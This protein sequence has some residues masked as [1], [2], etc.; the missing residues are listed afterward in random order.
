MHLFILRDGLVPGVKERKMTEIARFKR[1]QFV[2]TRLVSLILPGS[3]HVVG[4]RPL[5][6]VVLLSAWSSVWIA[7]AL[8]GRGLV[9]P[10]SILSAGGIAAYAPLAA[11][12][13]A[14]WIIANLSSHE[15]SGE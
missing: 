13:L 7:V 8:R 6:G 5:I 11:L 3:G 1:G 9:F 15:S 4:G 14:A 12:A 10:G 2:G